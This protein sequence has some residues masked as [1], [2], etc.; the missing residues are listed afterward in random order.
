MD[1]LVS[2]YRPIPHILRV[3][4]PTEIKPSFI[5]KRNVF[6]FSLFT[7]HIMKVPVHKIQSCFT[8][9]IHTCLTYVVANAAVLFHWVLMMQTRFFFFFFASRTNEFLGDVSN[10]AS[11]YSHFFS[12]LSFCFLLNS[13]EWQ[14]VL[15]TCLCTC[16]LLLSLEVANQENFLWIYGFSCRNCLSV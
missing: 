4:L 8:I 3:R 11:F 12:T 9:V 10:L 16:K 5:G 14:Q 13:L 6:E 15:E 7:M 1:Q 2:F